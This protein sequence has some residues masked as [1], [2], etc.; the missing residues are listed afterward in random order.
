MNHE[1]ILYSFQTGANRKSLIELYQ[2]NIFV[3]SNKSETT[4]KAMETQIIEIM[5]TI[6]II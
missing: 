1:Q 3:F 5:K 2:Y 4:F 6:V